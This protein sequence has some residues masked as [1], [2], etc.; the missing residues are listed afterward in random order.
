MKSK[1]FAVVCK[2]VSYK[3]LRNTY[4]GGPRYE[5]VILT[6]TGQYITGNTRGNY[7]IGY[8][9]LDE[10]NKLHKWVY[11]VGKRG[12]VFTDMLAVE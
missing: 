3:S 1:E 2:V 9:C 5:L 10:Q 7:K 12:L 8:T 11:S 4:Y 6:D